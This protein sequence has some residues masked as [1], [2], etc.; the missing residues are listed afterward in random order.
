MIRNRPDNPVVLEVSRLMELA[1][2]GSRTG[3]IERVVVT[4]ER[5][6]TNL[7]SSIGEY[8]DTNYHAF[9]LLT[10]CKISLYKVLV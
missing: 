1:S 3:Q 10:S 8:F 7:G 6:A 2:G 4:P 5:G 9:N